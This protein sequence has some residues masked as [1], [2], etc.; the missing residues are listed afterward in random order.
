MA[1]LLLAGA[2]ALSGCSTDKNFAGLSDEQLGGLFPTKSEVASAFTKGMSLRKPEVIP[3]SAVS[4]VTDE[5]NIPRDLPESCRNAFLGTDQSRAAAASKNRSIKVQ[6]SEGDSKMTIVLNQFP[7]SADAAKYMDAYDSISRECEFNTRFNL[8][9]TKGWG[10][11]T[12]TSTG[13]GATAAFLNVADITMT[14]VISGT[15]EKDAEAAVK[16]LAS[17]METRIKAKQPQ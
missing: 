14:V 17:L 13:Y 16:K 6:G 9:V 11:S 8:D 2:I 15:P 5:R 10:T 3:N 1:A 7:S 4:P 12:T